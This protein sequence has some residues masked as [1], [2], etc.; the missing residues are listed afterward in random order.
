MSSNNFGVTNVFVG[1]RHT[2]FQKLDKTTFSF[3]RNNRNRLIDGTSTNNIIPKLI[4]EQ[5]HDIIDVAVANEFTLILKDSGMVFGIGNNG[6]GQ[7]G[8]GTTSYRIVLTPIRNV[9]SN[10]TK[11]SAKYD[12]S[13]ILRNGLVYSFG[14]ND[15][16]QLGA[17]INTTQPLAKYGYWNYE[18]NYHNFFLCKPKSACP[19]G[20][21]ANCTIGYK[22]IRCGQCINRWY[23]FRGECIMGALALITGLFFALSSTKVHHIASIAIAVIFLLSFLFLYSILILRS[24]LAIPINWITTRFI[25]IKYLKPTAPFSDSDDEYLDNQMEEKKTKNVI[26][27][28]LMNLLSIRNVVKQKE[29]DDMFNTTKVLWDVDYEFEPFGFR[30]ESNTPEEE[31]SSMND[32]FENI[33]S[34][35]RI[36]RKYFL[37]KRK[38]GKATKKKIKKFKKKTKEEKELKDYLNS[39]KNE[40][41]ETRKKLRKNA[42]VHMTKEME[43]KYVKLELKKKKKQFVHEVENDIDDKKQEKNEKNSNT[44]KK[45]MKNVKKILPEEDLTPQ[46]RMKRENEER[47]KNLKGKVELK[48][49]STPTTPRKISDSERFDVID[50]DPEF[51]EKI[52]KSL[53]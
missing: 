43:D 1:F 22:G 52:F 25:K 6:V 13:M 41:D 40:E 20:G 29:I 8:D 50:L 18:N 4:E 23:K 37:A 17:E 39:L 46:E 31:F 7:L 27:K 14:R 34:W 11:I 49:K 2:F 35:K 51:S 16:F 26:A 3:G 24:T 10:I 30:T 12:F 36:K 32:I 38:G 47:K 48:P 45:L 28:F 53:K 44:L 19:G 5:N 15:S 33:L 9:N 42:S 21:P